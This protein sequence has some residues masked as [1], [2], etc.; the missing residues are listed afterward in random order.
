[1]S[2]IF[3]VLVGVAL[4]AT[5]QLSFASAVVSGLTG[6]A[7]AIPIA[8]S[9]RALSN[10]DKVNAGDT[11]ATSENSSL[12]LQF[13]DGQVVGLGARSRMAVSAYSYNVKEPAKS[14]VLLSLVSGSM[15]AITGIIGKAAPA[16]VTYRAGNATMG[17]RGTDVSFATAGGDVVVTVNN[18]AIAF[19]FGG[20]TISIPAGQAALT[21]KG[22]V[23][24]GTIA[25]INAAVAANPALA[26]ALKSVQSDALTKAVSEAALKAAQDASAA[27]AKAAADANAAADKAAAD[28]KAAA[29]KAAADAK[30]AADKVAA[31]VAAA[32]LAAA[33]LAADADAKSTAPGNTSLVGSGTGT[34]TGAGGTGSGGGGSASAR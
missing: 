27:A 25:A 3:A 5:C 32:K 6:S 21:S 30:V 11:V 13:E 12:A 26:A 19:T 22:Q 7:Q 18:G 14:N 15:R 2:K 28:A 33:K 31:D 17:I 10:G 4:A 9:P 23:T 29:D 20:K 34:G 8:G 1:M 16:Q 24:S